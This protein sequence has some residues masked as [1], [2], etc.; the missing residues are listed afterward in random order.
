MSL[1]DSIIYFVKILFYET[2][3]ICKKSVAALFYLQMLA[4]LDGNKVYS[5]DHI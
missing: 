4:I 5:W 3:Q 2:F 1:K